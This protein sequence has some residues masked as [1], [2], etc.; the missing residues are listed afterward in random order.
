MLKGDAFG[1]IC[2]T[3]PGDDEMVGMREKYFNF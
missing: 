1:K 2:D 3:M